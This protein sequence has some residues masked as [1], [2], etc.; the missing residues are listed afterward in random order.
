MR[1]TILVKL[2]DFCL[3][4]P[5]GRTYGEAEGELRILFPESLQET[6][7]TYLLMPSCRVHQLDLYQMCL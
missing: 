3:S 6:G 2:G 7:R 1:N 5:Y 4:E